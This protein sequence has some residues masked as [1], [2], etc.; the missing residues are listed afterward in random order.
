MKRFS[1]LIFH[2]SSLKSKRRF[3]LIELLVVIAI[4]AILAAMLLPALNKARDN[5]QAASCKNNLKQLGTANFQYTSA[6]DDCLVYVYE[7][8]FKFYYNGFYQLLPFF[9]VNNKT[10]P[11]FYY[12]PVYN[13]PTAKFRHC[14]D[15]KAVASYGFNQSGNKF[16]Y[17]AKESQLG[18]V[19]ARP[20]KI[21]TVKRPSVMFAM[22][23][24]RLNMQGKNGFTNWNIGTDGK[25][26]DANMAK[27][28][29]DLTEDPRFRHNGGLNVLFMDGHVGY[30]N[31]MMQMTYV[32]GTTTDTDI[33]AFWMG[34]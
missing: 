26:T 23:D 20:Q 5:A 2:L 4:I 30:N 31:H 28:Q 29:L 22:A 25:A 9:N 33:R 21:T 32:S 10:T 17:C 34:Y 12:M 1:S 24:G 19:A 7:G 3:T 6:Y 15:K 13:C 18:G 8:Y 11:S 14:Y 16:A 27:Y